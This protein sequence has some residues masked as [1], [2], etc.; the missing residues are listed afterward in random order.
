[1]LESLKKPI[2]REDSDLVGKPSETKR[3]APDHIR[4]SG[5]KI[6]SIVEESISEIPCRVSS[7]PHEWHN[8]S[9]TVS[10]RDSVKL[11]GR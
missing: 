8:D 2:S 3:Y 11:Q 10:T 5:M 1:M 9:W 7:D 4:W 6:E